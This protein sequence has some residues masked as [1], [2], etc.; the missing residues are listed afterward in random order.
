MIMLEI[1]NGFFLFESI[2]RENG[3]WNR[4][5]LFD[6]TGNI[7]TKIKGR[8]WEDG[9]IVGNWNSWNR[10][11]LLGNVMLKLEMVVWRV[12]GTV[13]RLYQVWSANVVIVTSVAQ[14]LNKH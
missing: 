11:E 3:F 10:L 8:S 2:E 9:I 13:S 4:I 5:D 12:D 1:W 6:V 7:I 14:P